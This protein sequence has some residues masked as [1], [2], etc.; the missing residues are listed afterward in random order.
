MSLALLRSH[1]RFSWISC[2]SVRTFHVE[3]KT[4]LTQ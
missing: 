3:L 4:L 1:T 2:L